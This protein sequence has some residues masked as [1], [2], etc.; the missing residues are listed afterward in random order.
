MNFRIPSARP[1]WQMQTLLIGVAAAIAMTSASAYAQ[2]SPTP[3]TGSL[4][5]ARPTT[6][7]AKEAGIVRKHFA[8]CVYRASERKVAE[9]LAHSD[10]SNVGWSAGRI[11]NVVTDLHMVDCLG[12]Q[13]GA[14]QMELSFMPSVLRD[15][16]AEEAYLA[17][18]ATVPQLAPDSGPLTPTFVSTGSELAVAQGLMTFSDC[19][20]RHN[21]SGADALLRTMPASAEEAAAARALAPALGACLVQGQTF[22]LKP[23]NIRSFIAYA[24][25]SRFGR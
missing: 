6:V 1:N 16:M 2:L 13:Q 9:L 7:E 22:A 8:Q 12:K 5:F 10:I 25:W 3:Q 15:L 19:A 20:V 17:K 21:I 18:N 4:L 24:M 11:A 14:N 23:A